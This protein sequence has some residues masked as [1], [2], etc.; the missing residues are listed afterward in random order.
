MTKANLPAAVK[1]SIAKICDKELGRLAEEASEH[2]YQ[3]TE[4]IR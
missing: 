4:N 1:R 3:P 2:S